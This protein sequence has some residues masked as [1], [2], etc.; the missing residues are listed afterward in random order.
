MAKTVTISGEKTGERVTVRALIAA[1]EKALVWLRGRDPESTVDWEIV[2]VSLAD[3]VSMTFSSPTANGDI[4]E[5]MRNLHK[6]QSKKRPKVTPRLTDEDIDGTRELAAT[7]GAEFKSLRISSPGEPT[8]KLTPILVE[9][10]EEIAKTARAAWYEWGTMRGTMDQVTIGENVSKF[11]MKHPVTGDEV[12]CTFPQEML[13]DV[14]D[15]LPHRVEVYGRIRYNRSDRPTSI[16]VREIRRLPERSTSFDAVRPVNITSGID[17][18][19][20]V[21]GLRGDE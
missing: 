21:E 16:D 17:S 1:L 19:D 20:Y 3:P 12:G 14:K 9:R 13:D 2:R 5:R 8:V 18:A 10:V 4:S 11:R 6:L 15:A 7:I